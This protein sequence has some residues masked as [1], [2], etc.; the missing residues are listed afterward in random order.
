MR[1]LAVFCKLAMFCAVIGFSENFTL[2]ASKCHSDDKH[3]IT[4]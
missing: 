3:E 2:T 1:R 4:R